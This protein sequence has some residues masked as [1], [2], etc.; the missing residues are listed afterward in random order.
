MHQN[1]TIGQAAMSTKTKDHFIRWK[2]TAIFVPIQQPSVPSV[3]ICL[4]HLCT[5]DRL[6]NP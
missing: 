2:H 4:S 5:A 3:R 1:E 6:F